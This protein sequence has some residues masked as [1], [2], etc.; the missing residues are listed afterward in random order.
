M[1]VVLLKFHLLFSIT[2]RQK[3]VAN[4]VS[5]LYKINHIKSVPQN[6]VTHPPPY[7]I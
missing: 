6:Y 4:D 1:K 5:L 3:R 7:T 2:F